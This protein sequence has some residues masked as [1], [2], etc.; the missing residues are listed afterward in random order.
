MY[1][2]EELSKD[3]NEE[4][5]PAVTNGFP[6]I[7]LSYNAKTAE[8]VDKI[9]KRAKKAGAILQKEPTENDWVAMEV[10]LQTLMVIIGK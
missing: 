1:P 8:E 5:P 3:V 9:L 6:E 10:I 4:N 7:T 2:I